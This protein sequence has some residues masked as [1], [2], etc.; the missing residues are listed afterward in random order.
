MPNHFHLMLRQ[1][2][3]DGIKQ[4]MHRISNSF[5]HY[6]AIK[7][8]QRGHV[9]EGN[10]KAVHVETEEQLLHLSRYIHLNPVTAYLVNKPED[11]P[12]SSYRVYL[13]E[14]SSEIVD[15]TVAISHFSSREKYREFVMLQK[16]YQRK[17]QEIKHLLLE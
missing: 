11:Y 6:Y 13:G 15:P 17:L 1:E 2:K 12:H 14:E 16:D 4:F 7:N 8:K 9:F 10:F 3:D 5:A